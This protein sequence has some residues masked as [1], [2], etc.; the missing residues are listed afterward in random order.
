MTALH[1]AIVG[2]GSG[3]FAAAIK[4]AENGARVTMIEDISNL[5]HLF[6]ENQKDSFGSRALSYS[7][8]LKID[9]I[10]TKNVH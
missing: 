9:F 7:Y 3:A 1:I 6:A 5:N 4:A 2:T 10:R 8:L